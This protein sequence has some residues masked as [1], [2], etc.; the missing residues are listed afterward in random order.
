MNKGKYQ[1]ALN[2]VE[3]KIKELRTR[4]PSKKF[5]KNKL[6]EVEINKFYFS[7]KTV[8]RIMIVL[9]ANGCEHYKKNGGC[10]MCSHFNGTMPNDKILDD[11]YIN[12]WN[13]VL[14]GSC[15]EKPI[16]NFSLNNFP[17]VC[18]YNLGSLLNLNE[19]SLNAIEYIFT[20]LNNFTN[21]QKV[22]IESRAEYVD[23]NIL[24]AIKSYYN[25]L[26]E[27]G[28]GV[29][30][31]NKSIRQLCHHKGLESLSTIKKAIKNLHNHGYKALAYVNFKPCF[32]TEKEAIDDAIKTSVDCFNF[33]FDSV[34]IE[35]TSLQEYSLTNHL[36]NLGY[37]RV[38]W[39]W[40]L[41]EIV[42]G[43]YNKIDTKEKYIDI[44][45]WGYFDEEV[46]SGSQ[47]EGFTSKNEIFPHETSSNCPKC[48]KAFIDCIK[49][50]NMTYDLNDLLN[51]KKC[52]DCYLT[53]TEVC[54]IKDSRLLNQR[55][56]DILGNE[57]NIDNNIKMK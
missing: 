3:D 26:I 46:L 38:P 12:Q 48:T 43:I 40:S 1:L 45:I 37:Y 22:I 18:I 56:L 24:K 5:N 20:S 32:L 39:L 8:D 53:W 13:S 52:N 14:T 10:A 2:I 11:N 6:A 49:K 15:L 23:E 41:Q 35:P 57:K 42:K 29:E 33:G 16:K 36:Y 50:F 47:G 55:I 51:I 27:V 44:R 7:G 31:T 34:S 30:S 54:K 25:G 28:I 9:R 17:V 19:I 21:I 4:V